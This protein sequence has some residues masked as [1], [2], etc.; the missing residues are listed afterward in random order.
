[1]IQSD[2]EVTTFKKTGKMYALGAIVIETE[3]G[4]FDEVINAVRRMR[5][6]KRIPGLQEGTAIFGEYHLLVCVEDVVA[7]DAVNPGGLR[8]I[9]AD[10]PEQLPTPRRLAGPA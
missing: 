4:H 5:R 2:V 1:M 9:P 6:E 7:G 3:S 10:E 8:L